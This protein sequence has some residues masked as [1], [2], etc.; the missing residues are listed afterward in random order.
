M[1]R[2]LAS[3][4]GDTPIYD[5]AVTVVSTVDLRQADAPAALQ[6]ALTSTGFVELVGHDLDTEL[7]TELRRVCDAFFALDHSVKTAFVHQDPAANRGYRARG[8]EALSYSL[9]EESPPDLFES[10]N[11]APDPNGEGHRLLQATPWPD[12]LVPEFSEIAT[13]S[14]NDFSELSARLDVMIGDLLEVDWLADRS[15]RGPDML[16]AINY[17]PEPDGTER[18]LE[19]QQRMGAHSDYTTFT[20]LD[21][22]PVRGLQIVAPDGEWVDVLP[23]EDGLL[24]NVGDVLAM[25]TNNV[26]PSTLHRVIPMAAGAASHRRSVAYFHYPNLDVTFEPLERYVGDAAPMYQPVT[27][28]THLLDKIVSPKT[29]TLTEAASTTA[30]RSV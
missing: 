21:A 2:K 17:R 22:D 23:S 5:D 26:W 11:S 6:S 24:M 18:T 19:G 10:F 4:S 25:M 7:R 8:S 28:E 14:F 12:D 30:G 1:P 29:Q 3:A 20:L 27:V 9:G 16:A 13:A 15:G